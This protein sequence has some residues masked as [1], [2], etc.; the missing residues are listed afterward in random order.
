MTATVDS[1]DLDLTSLVTTLQGTVLRPGDAGYDDEVATFNLATRHR[2]PVVVAA[3]STADVAAAVR[4]AAAHGLPVGVQATGHGPATAIDDGVLVSTK[5]M[6][7]VRVDPST[8]TATVGAG[9]KWR[10][11]IDAAAPY[12]LAPLCGSN[13]DVGVV[14]YT[15]GGGL[16]LLGR[17][18]GFAADH[19]Q[20][21]TVVTADGVVREATPER[22]TDLFWGLRG[23]KGNLG[24]ITE[25]TVDLVPIDRF[26]GGGIYYPGE[27][28]AAVVRA[29]REW[30]TTLDEKANASFAL[31]RLPPI[32]D[33]PEPLR[34]KFVVHVRLA[35]VGSAADGERIVEPMRKVAPAI[36][37]TLAE[38]P[39]T[40]ADTIFN[41]PDHP[42]PAHERSLLLRDLDD[43][44][45]DHLLA[46]AGPDADLPVLMIDVRQLG[47]A[48]GRSPAVP[49]AVG[50]RDAGYALIAIGALM[51]PIADAVPAAVD[52]LMASFE[53]FSTG[54]S[55]V[56]LHGRPGDAADRARPWAPEVYTRLCALKTAYDPTR[57]F[58]F[59]HAVPDEALP[60][61][62]TS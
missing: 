34:G 29:F 19:V 12:S 8:R 51:P 41:D 15:A 11:V 55:M 18:F 38:M 58:R 48:L 45:V 5:H 32:P 28:A 59:G 46:V 47:G 23:G 4:F 44:A 43:A 16:P 22:E 1:A 27:H 36:V 6:A 62:L 61:R 60:R 35:Y 14:G 31:L 53:P 21:F 56:N 17:T 10:A 30:A 25:M 57:M 49:N 7:D 40:A 33:V 20:A 39:Y 50:S 3:H 42:I 54:R 13:S 24:I 2:P 9:V 52:G 26:Y 37:D